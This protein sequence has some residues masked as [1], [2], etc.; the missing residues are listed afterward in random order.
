MFIFA[1]FTSKSQWNRW[2]FEKKTNPNCSKHLSIIKFPTPLRAHPR[3]YF[4]ALIPGFG[5]FWASFL[6]FFQVF[7]FN[8]KKMPQKMTVGCQKEKQPRVPIEMKSCDLGQ[9]VE[10]AVSNGRW[11][12]QK[13]IFHALRIRGLTLYINIYRRVLGSEKTI[14]FEISWFLGWKVLETTLP[15]AM[16]MCKNTTIPVTCWRIPKGFLNSSCSGLKYIFPGFCSVT[17]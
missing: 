14:S 1:E 10:T 7:L 16:E 5:C 11:W 4:L 15:V 12:F 3:F 8:Q 9:L 13:K 2:K 17:G 6:V